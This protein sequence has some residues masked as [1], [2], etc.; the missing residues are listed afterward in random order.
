M[1]MQ[2]DSSNHPFKKVENLRVT[3]IPAKDRAPDKD[4]AGYDV[5]RIQAYKNDHDESLHMG[6]ELP[7][8]SP[9]V[10]VELIAAL[11]DIYSEGRKGDRSGHDTK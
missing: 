10:F 3:F 6:S 7:I 11:C 4:W 9:D 2:K 1:T 8:Y 5:L